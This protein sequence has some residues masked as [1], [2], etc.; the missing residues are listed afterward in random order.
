M[1]TSWGY[2]QLRHHLPHANRCGVECAM[3]GCRGPRSKILYDMLVKEVCLYV[4]PTVMNWKRC[5]NFP[6]TCVTLLSPQQPSTTNH[7]WSQHPHRP[8]SSV[9][10]TLRALPAPLISLSPHL[11]GAT[12]LASEYADRWTSPGIALINFFVSFVVVWSGFIYLTLSPS[13]NS[14]P[15]SNIDWPLM[16]GFNSG[17]T[18]VWK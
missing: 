5:L 3:K 11:L 17:S 18:I 8:I 16:Q 12:S 14:A 13:S 4:V 2:D 10:D 6:K 7:W 9:H 15:L 1:Y